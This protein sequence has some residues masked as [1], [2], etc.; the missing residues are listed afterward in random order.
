TI[1]LISQRF[2]AAHTLSGWETSREIV[3]LLVGLALV[4][5]GVSRKVRSTTLSGAATLIAYVVSLVGLI[6][7]PDHLQSTSVY[8]MAGGGL[9]FLAAAALSVYRDRLVELPHKVREGKGL[10]SVLKWR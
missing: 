5:A 8:M 3:A 1:G 9:L 2:A 10:F 7:L 6:E 4:G